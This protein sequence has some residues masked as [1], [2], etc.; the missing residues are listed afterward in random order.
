MRVWSWNVYCYNKKPQEVLDFVRSRSTNVLCLQEVP[1]TLLT[2]LEALFPFSTHAVDS[3]RIRHKERLTLYNVILSP[4]PLEDAKPVHHTDISHPFRTKMTIRALASEGWSASTGRNA[5]TATAHTP[6]GHIQIYSAHL[7]LTSPTNRAR[8]YAELMSHATNLPKIVAGDFNI[9]ERPRIK[10][11]NWFLG[12]SLHESMPWYS[13]RN[14]FEQRFANSGLGNPL[15]G[16]VT[17]HFSHSQLDHILVPYQ[18]KV[19]SSGVHPNMHGSDH[20][21][22]FV[23][24]APHA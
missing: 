17:H 15:R 12:A 9:I 20:K 13:E 4:Y 1:E 11:L 21:A 22:V 3:T 19:E 5:V 14:K 2:D 18:F 8:E 10:I 16:T 7:T 6:I 23:E 24:I